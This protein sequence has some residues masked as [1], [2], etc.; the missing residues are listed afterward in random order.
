M[1]YYHKSSTLLHSTLLGVE[2]LGCALENAGQ[3]P[4]PPA[5]LQTMTVLQLPQPTLSPHTATSYLDKIT[6]EKF[7]IIK[8][9]LIT[10]VY[11]GARWIRIKSSLLPLQLNQSQ[12]FYLNV[13]LILK[14]AQN[15]SAHRSQVK[16]WIKK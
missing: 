3:H 11:L 15:I 7:C 8:H 14:Y 4:F 16:M 2:E 12:A 9:F 10:I 1:K 13:A 5:T 6:S